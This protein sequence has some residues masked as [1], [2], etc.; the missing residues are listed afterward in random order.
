MLWLCC[1]SLLR[2]KHSKEVFIPL[3]LEDKTFVSLSF[4]VHLYMSAAEVL[5]PFFFIYTVF[6]FLLQL[7]MLT[8]PTMEGVL[9]AATIA[10]VIGSVPYWH[11]YITCHITF[12][13]HAWLPYLEVEWMVVELSEKAARPV[14]A[15]R[16]C[17]WTFESMKA[18]DI[19]KETPGHCPAKFVATT[20]VFLVQNVIFRCVFF[21]DKPDHEHSIVTT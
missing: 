13:L 21:F 16:D 20:T 4:V 18:L 14:P 5:L 7:F 8:P 9:T 6:S 17:S 11:F 19:F 12:T 2:S 1:G 3:N 10:R 15:V